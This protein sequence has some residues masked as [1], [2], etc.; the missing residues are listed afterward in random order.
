MQSAQIIDLK[1]YRSRR[2]PA[3]P[4]EPQNRMP[5]EAMSAPPMP[6][7]WVPV[8]YWVPVKPYFS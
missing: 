8:I 6:V 4:A 1:S 7:M 5:A 3:G 2:Q